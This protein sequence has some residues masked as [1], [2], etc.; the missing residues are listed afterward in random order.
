MNSE[1]PS[2][3]EAEPVQTKEPSGEP[4]ELEDSQLKEVAGGRGETLQHPDRT[5]EK[6]RL[7]E[8]G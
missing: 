5:D 7:T 6:E 3:N 8:L 1:Q 2:K 4:V